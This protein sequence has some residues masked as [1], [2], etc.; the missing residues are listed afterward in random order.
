MYSEMCSAARIPDE[1]RHRSQYFR[2]RDEEAGHL[3]IQILGSDPKKMAA[4]ARRIESEG[5]FGVDINLGCST[6][7]IC[8]FNQGAALLKNPDQALAIIQ[9]V[10][11]TVRCPLTVKFRT[12]WQDMPQFAVDMA[13]RIEEAGADAL[14]FHPRVAPDRRTRPPKWEYIGRIKQAV[15]IP[16]FGNGNVFTAEDCLKMLDITG[17]DGIALGR[18]AIARPWAFSAWTGGAHQLAPNYLEGTLTLLELLY[19]HFDPEQALR[20]FK[21]MEL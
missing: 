5:L 17:C 15:S 3:M 11:K 6:K 16:V 4:A 19:Q 9:L 2:W 20:R 12:G 10:R 21:K 7:Q 1:N 14:V 8:R 18:I 13:K